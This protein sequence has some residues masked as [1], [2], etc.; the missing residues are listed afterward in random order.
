LTSINHRPKLS[1][2]SR[3]ILPVPTEC[4]RP[5]ER[6]RTDSVTVTPC[7]QQ[8]SVQKTEQLNL[9][10]RNYSFSF[11]TALSLSTH[12]R[13]KHPN[14]DTRPLNCEN[15]NGPTNHGPS[16]TNSNIIII[17]FGQQIK[18]NSLRKICQPTRTRTTHNSPTTRLIARS[19]RPTCPI[20][21]RTRN[22]PNMQLRRIRQL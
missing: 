20:T 22:T 11:T 7:C 9:F 17:I 3:V 15:V 6:T 13:E 2:F 10:T 19:T 14:P 12:S 1:N 8:I 18:K 21:T 5:A 16:S 4:E